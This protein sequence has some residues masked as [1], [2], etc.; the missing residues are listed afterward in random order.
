MTEIA[1]GTEASSSAP[2][3][4]GTHPRRRDVQGL[5][6]LAVALVV[7][8]HAGLPLSGGYVGVDVFFVIS[9]FV[10]TGMLSAE[11]ARTGRI[12]LGGFYARRVRRIL[13]ALAVTV[14]VV[15]VLSVFLLNPM[16]PQQQT[17][18]TGEAAS[19]FLANFQLY[20]NPAGYFDVT[21]LRNALLHTWSLSV[22][23]QFYLVFPALLWAAWYA[24]ARGRKRRSSPAAVAIVL[25][26]AAAASFG[27]SL[28]MS[29]SVG[30]TGASAESARFAFYSSPTRAWEF[31][32]GALIALALPALRRLSEPTA[33]VAGAVGLVAIAVSAVRFD[34][35][36]SFPG[37]AAL[38]PVV[39]TCLV[40]MAGTA[41]T[42]GVTGLLGVEA[43]VRVGDVSY[44]WYLWHWPFIVFAAAI[45]PTSGSAVAVVAAGLSLVP[46]AL[47]YVLVENRYRFRRDLTGRRVLPLAGVCIAVPLVLCLLVVSASRLVQSD[48]TK[49]LV[50]SHDLHADVVRGCDSLEP[51]AARP[52]SCTWP[53]S[54]PHGSVVLVGDSNAGHFTEPAAA[55]SNALGYDFVAATSSGCGFVELVTVDAGVESSACRDHVSDTMRSLVESRPAAVII[56]DSTAGIIGTD[57]RWLVDPQTGEIAR[58]R[59]QKLA[60]YRRHLTSEMDALERAGIDALLV[61]T[62]PQF[63]RWNPVACGIDVYLSPSSCATTR[64]RADLE[65]VAAPDFQAEQGALDAVPSATGLDLAD[66]LCGPSTCST[67]PGATWVYRDGGHLSVLGSEGLTPQFRQALETALGSPAP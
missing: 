65:T 2:P 23:E 63:A 20:A 39:G 1:A 10:I 48:G 57:A 44:S 6:A 62:I 32:A 9:G 59:E 22:E 45:W 30:A 19:V 43:A 66:A 17:A 34:A 40:I 27:L 13:P 12:G 26:A 14:G 28:A 53:V 58:S 3:A 7:A 18:K 4:G 8:F 52:A 60:L 35:T 15:A 25:A 24:V 55:A 38:L 37:T 29:G 50:A 64:S 47:S 42:R 61:H 67:R 46:A 41:T 11:H 21:E 51:I 33:V 54:D 31:L 49:A 16:G 36:T 5:R 56:A